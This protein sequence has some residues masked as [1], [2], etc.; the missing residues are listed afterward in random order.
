MIFS[1]FERAIVLSSRVVLLALLASFASA[2]AN[3]TVTPVPQFVGDKSDK[4]DNITPVFVID[5]RVDVFGGDATFVSLADTTSIH[6]WGGSCLGSD[7]ANPKSGAFLIGATTAQ[8]IEFN[9]P[10]TSFG[11][12][13]TNTSS[14]DDAI[15]TFFD[16]NGGFIGAEVVNIPVQ[17]KQWY[18][19]GW[20]S[21]V[22]I[23]RIE[24][25][26]QGFLEGFLWFDNMQLSY[27]VPATCT[28][29]N[30]NG[31]N[32]AGFTCVA[33]PTLGTNWETA[34]NTTPSLGTVTAGTAIM[35]GFGGPSTGINLPGGEL[36]ALSPYFYDI[37]VGSDL[38]AHSIQLPA[39]PTL[40]GVS[41][42]TQGLRVELTPAFKS[43]I[44]LLNA[45]DLVLGA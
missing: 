8:S 29:R 15:A 3:G 39:D 45:L 32:E 2:R 43:E 19:N 33:P 27:S 24:F 30:G 28:F 4:L 12:F 1:K 41:L 17:G 35:I 31:S 16:V 34:I 5:Q 38:G 37:N 21:D 42:Y 22:A 40:A 13:F 26:G 18:W 9:V 44:V 10:V 20:E 14:K 36:L 25:H 23:G 11:S 6:L 7:C